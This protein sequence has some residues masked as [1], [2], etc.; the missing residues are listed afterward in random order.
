MI[1]Y[2]KIYIEY[3]AVV[4]TDVFPVIEVCKY[5]ITSFIPSGY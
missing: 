4:S 2:V 1:R 5:A 3:T